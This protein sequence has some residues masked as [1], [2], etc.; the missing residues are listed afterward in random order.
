MR[1]LLDAIWLC[2]RRGELVFTGLCV[3]MGFIA[4]VIVGGVRWVF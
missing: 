1:D 4:L 3:V 2:C